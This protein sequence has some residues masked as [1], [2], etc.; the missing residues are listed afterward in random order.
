M[1]VGGTVGCELCIRRIKWQVIA[2]MREDGYGS[3][4]QVSLGRGEEG[5]TEAKS[6]RRKQRENGG[7][8]LKD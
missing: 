6:G 8:K 4:G 5:Q 1:E 2:E 7:L 3:S